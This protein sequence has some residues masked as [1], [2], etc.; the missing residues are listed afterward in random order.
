MET[1][2]QFSAGKLFMYVPAKTPRRPFHASHRHCTYE[3]F[4]RNSNQEVGPGQLVS[5]FHRTKFDSLFRTTREDAW[6]DQCG[7]GTYLDVGNGI[8]ADFAFY[9]GTHTH[10]K[11]SGTNFYLHF[12]LAHMYLEPGEVIVQLWVSESTKLTGG[13]WGRYCSTCAAGIRNDKVSIAGIHIPTALLAVRVHPPP[14]PAHPLVM[15]SFTPT[16]PL[17]RHSQAI[18]SWP[19]SGQECAESKQGFE[20]GY[21]PLRI[22]EHLTILSGAEAGHATNSFPWYIYCKNSTGS[23][24]WVPQLLLHRHGHGSF[25]V[26][27]G[28]GRH[29]ELND[30]IVRVLGRRGDGRVVANT[31]D[32]RIIAV[33]LANV[34]CI[35]D[36][37][38]DVEQIQQKGRSGLKFAHPDKFGCAESF[39]LLR[40][41]TA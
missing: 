29:K 16:T 28:L 41:I 38:E 7:G 24:G 4:G 32:M 22:G 26:I 5:G 17:E 33:P 35:L 39:A 18:A 1:S 34:V 23:R 31:K 36:F 30:S 27:S 13:Q 10:C 15:E 6:P 2:P 9:G 12:Q 14:P 25:G 3:L 37:K 20:H 40:M 21:L 11:K 8:L 19:Y